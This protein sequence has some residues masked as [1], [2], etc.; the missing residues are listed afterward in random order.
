VIVDKYSASEFPGYRAQGVAF[1]VP[2]GHPMARFAT[3]QTTK[4]PDAKD[5][6]Q[7]KERV[8]ELL[9]REI[10]GEP[11]FKFN[12]IA[13]ETNVSDQYVRNVAK[14]VLSAEEYS[15]RAP[16]GGNRKK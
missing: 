16:W 10:N 3:E 7:I 1:L 9:Q 2:K 6:K 11:E 15:S 14:E 8:V 12:Q 4:D 5:W 13:E